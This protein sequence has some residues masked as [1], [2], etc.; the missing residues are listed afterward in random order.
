MFF[1]NGVVFNKAYS[2][3]TDLTWEWCGPSNQRHYRRLVPPSPLP[4]A[5]PGASSP[6]PPAHPAAAL[7]LMMGSAPFLRLLCDCTDLA[8]ASYERL[9]LQ[10]WRPGD[11]TVSAA[12]YTLSNIAR[13]LCMTFD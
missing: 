12:A 3:P 5:P 2:I 10:R 1:N 11:F 4:G 8:L 13:V 6:A 7:L 9:E